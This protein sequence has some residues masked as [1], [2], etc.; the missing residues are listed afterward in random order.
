MFR[1]AGDKSGEWALVAELA[2][3]NGLENLLQLRMNLV[4]AVEV[5]VTEVFDVLGEV[6]EEEDVLVTCLTGDFDL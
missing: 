2:A 5:C 6:S 4:L 3:L 1:D